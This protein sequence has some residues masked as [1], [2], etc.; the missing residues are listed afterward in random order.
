MLRCSDVQA[1]QQVNHKEAVFF[2]AR[3]VFWSSKYGEIEL[4]GGA[5]KAVAKTYQSINKNKPIKKRIS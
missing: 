3:G 4:A 5:S 1:R 2:P